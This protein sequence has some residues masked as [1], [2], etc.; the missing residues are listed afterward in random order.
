VGRGKAGVMWTKEDKTR[1]LPDLSTR[2]CVQ[3]RLA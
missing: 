3:T 1:I 2:N